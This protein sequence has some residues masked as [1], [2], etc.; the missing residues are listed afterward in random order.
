M[1]PKIPKIHKDM[2]VGEVVGMF[3]EA[4]DII[5]SYGLH[6]VGCHANAFETL[7]QGLLGHGYP[8]QQ[9][10]KLIDELNEYAEELNQEVPKKLPAKAKQ[11][12]ISVTPFALKKIQEIAQKQ[13]R[14]NIFLRVEVRRAGDAYKYTLNFIDEAEKQTSEKT[15]DFAKGKV[16]IVADQW[17]H[18]KLNGLKI[19]YVIEEDR[20]GFK[21]KNPN[22]A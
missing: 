5:S 15:F 18:E 14:K 19:D 11:M 10:H 4:A 8:E 13:E 2:V 17:D 12:K 20:E 21:M 22:V 7:E 16:H 3:P 1:P 6:C 9:L